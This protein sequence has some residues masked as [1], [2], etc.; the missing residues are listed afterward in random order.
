MR[1]KFVSAPPRPYTIEVN[2]GQVNT[3]R[4]AAG[5]SRLRFPGVLV[6]LSIL[7]AG[8]PTVYRYGPGEGEPAPSARRGRLPST[9][10][11]NVPPTTKR[12]LTPPRAASADLAAQLGDGTLA[13]E[14]L[15]GARR[16][17]G[18]SFGGQDA[19]RFRR[20]LE[21]VA[22]WQGALEPIG[23]PRPGDVWLGPAG[24]LAV[25]EGR[26]E[27]GRW[28]V[29]GPS[30]GGA[31]ARFEVDGGRFERAVGAESEARRRP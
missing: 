29:I 16:L 27:S 18:F 3:T 10:P 15:A 24:T 13:G 11:L 28:R 14:L 25:V 30:S 23:M 6:A 2:F 19:A 31:V 1:A 8:C 22:V 20:H 4:G 5:S 12:P 7:L 17:I 9:R 21:R 26:G